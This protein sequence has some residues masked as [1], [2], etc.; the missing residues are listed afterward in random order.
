LTIRAQRIVLCDL[1]QT[2]EFNLMLRRLVRKRP[3][4]L[5][6][7]HGNGDF[8][9]DAAGNN[10]IG[11]FALRGDEFVEIRLHEAEPLLYAALDVAAALFDV[12]H[13]TPR[14]AQVGVGFGEDFEVEEVEDALV[15]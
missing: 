15:V 5:V 13:E 9:L 10:E 2:L 7:Y 4:D 8:V 1:A 6:A 11:K 12:A 14:E 3:P